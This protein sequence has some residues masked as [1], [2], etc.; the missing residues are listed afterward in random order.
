MVEI[1]MAYKNC[2][3]VFFRSFIEQKLHTCLQ[4]IPLTSNYM[5]YI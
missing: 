5:L 1:Y 3:V 4:H 2:Q